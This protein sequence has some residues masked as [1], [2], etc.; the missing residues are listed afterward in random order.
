M[1]LLHLHQRLCLLCDA[2]I[3]YLKVPS[4]KMK[5]QGMKP[6]QY[7][8]KQVTQN[9]LQRLPIHCP[10]ASVFVPVLVNCQ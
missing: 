2:N 7:G 9:L 1:L 8:M 6:C 3:R 5:R 4:K 10:K